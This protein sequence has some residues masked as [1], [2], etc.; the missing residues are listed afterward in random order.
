[1]LADAQFDA[2]I[3]YSLSHSLMMVC[4]YLNIACGHAYRQN[5]LITRIDNKPV[6]ANRSRKKITFTL[7]NWRRLFSH[8]HTY[9]QCVHHLQIMPIQ[10]RTLIIDR[11]ARIAQ[12]DVDI[13]R[14][15]FCDDQTIVFFLPTYLKIKTRCILFSYVY[16]MRKYE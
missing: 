10:S 4:L 14:V 2:A 13:V 12:Q 1:M 7:I 16:A 15:H 6:R 8:T 3:L 11:S 5:H 9:T